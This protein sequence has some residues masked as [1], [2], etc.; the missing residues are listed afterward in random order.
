MVISY[1]FA[2]RDGVQGPQGEK[3]ATGEPGA[4]GVPG[5]GSPGLKGVP[6]SRGLQG[7]AGA[8]GERGLPGIPGM[9]AQTGS[10]YTRWGQKSCAGNS[11][12]IYQGKK[13]QRM[14]LCTYQLLCISIKGFTS[15][16]DFKLSHIPRQKAWWK[17]SHA[18]GRKGSTLMAHT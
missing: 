9:L 11:S 6:G 12:L 17:N 18:V 3:G 4:P 5:T 13:E 1:L 7:V 10:V 16:E 14:D 15:N 2:G 8:P